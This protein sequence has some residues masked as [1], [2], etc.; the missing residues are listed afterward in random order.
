MPD[1]PKGVKGEI[2]QR[3]R[4]F[5]ESVTVAE[6]AAGW[7]VMLDGR[8]L[9]TPEKRLLAVQSEPLAKVIAD[10]WRKQ[11]D[12]I[13][14]QWMFNTRL[15]NVALDRTP[16]TRTALADEA[17]KYVETDLTCHLADAPE[18]LRARQEAAWAPLREWAERQIGVSLVPV[19]G[20]IPAAQPRSSTENVRRH[21]LGLNDFSLTGLVHCIALTGSAVLGLAVEQRRVTACEAFELSRIDEAFQAGLWGEDAE[22]LRRA[23]RH[24]AEAQA[25]DL[26][27]TALR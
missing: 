27:F 6:G 26:W 19:T 15:A 7:A 8:P 23:D 2:D 3:P 11:E 10:E 22:A 9:R 13:D 5:Y 4:R 12:R 25:L 21:A 24:R 16:M 20:I 18:A 14:L 1:F 17:A